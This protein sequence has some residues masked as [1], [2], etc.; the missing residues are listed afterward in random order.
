[1]RDARW[2]VPQVSCRDIV[3]KAAA[4]LIEAGNAGVAI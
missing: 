2:K 3:D 4:G 1:M